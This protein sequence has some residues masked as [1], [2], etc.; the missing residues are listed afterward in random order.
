MEEAQ[1]QQWKCVQFM[2]CRIESA[3]FFS[4][5]TVPSGIRVLMLISLGI[6]DAQLVNHDNVTLAM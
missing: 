5:I 1:V 3:W 4:L 2:D 6:K